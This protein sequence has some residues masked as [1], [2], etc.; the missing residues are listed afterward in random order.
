VWSPWSRP[1]RSFYKIIVP[2]CFFCLFFR[3]TFYFS[4]F[5]SND[6]GL[7]ATAHVDAWFLISFACCY[8]F[9]KAFWWFLII[10]E[11]FLFGFCDFHVFRYLE[12][13]NLNSVIAINL[14]TKLDNIAF[15]VVNMFLASTLMI[16]SSFFRLHRFYWH[17]YW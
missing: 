17:L 9:S 5:Y 3:L 2:S 15:N 7:S 14:K 16:F 4:I 13:S 12:L 11:C 1:A 8:D 10:L 6:S